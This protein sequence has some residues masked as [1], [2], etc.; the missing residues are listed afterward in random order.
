[1]KA[2]FDATTLKK[3][4]SLL[5]G[6]VNVVNLHFESDALYI[7]E[8]DPL[9]TSAYVVTI[10]PLTLVEWKE[11]V[12]FGFNV[13]ELYNRLRL[14]KSKET[15]EF[16]FD[17]S[18][19]TLVVRCVKDSDLITWKARFENNIT[20]VV[21]IP[22]VK[23]SKVASLKLSRSLL[24]VQMIWSSCY[25]GAE[26]TLELDPANDSFLLKGDSSETELIASVSTFEWLQIPDKIYQQ[27]YL[28]RYIMQVLR[29][30]IDKEIRIDL[31]ENGILVLHYEIEGKA[32]FLC[33]LSAITESS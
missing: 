16:A 15:L 13:G 2:S 18:H 11:P 31:Y 33:R 7:R 27:K 12:V 22:E 23:S 20:P 1:M 5:K 30:E 10:M 4:I 19:M 26:I 24:I 6:I 14:S 25:I 9:H 29:K 3:I 21:S 32:K 8:I 17:D 28:S